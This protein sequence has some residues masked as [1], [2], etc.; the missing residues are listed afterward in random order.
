L[1]AGLLAAHFPI[2][3]HAAEAT[4][5]QY[6]AVSVVSG[7]EGIWIVGDVSGKVKYCLSTREPASTYSKG[8]CTS[9]SEIAPSSSGY[10]FK[11]VGSDLY[12]VSKATGSIQLCSAFVEKLYVRGNCIKIGSLEPV[13]V[14]KK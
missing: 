3:L 2:A 14:P 9:L 8:S 11:I 6:E 10:E 5:Q 1:T 7:K 4:P 13:P 12:V